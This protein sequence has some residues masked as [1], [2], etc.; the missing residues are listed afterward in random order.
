VPDR[1]DAVAA[2]ARPADPAARASNWS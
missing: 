1:F 2:W